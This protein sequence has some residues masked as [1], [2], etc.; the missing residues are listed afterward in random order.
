MI[1]F[2]LF[3]QCGRVVVAVVFKYE[4]GIQVGYHRIAYSLA[5]RLVV[6]EAE[7]PQ[8]AAS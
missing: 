5:C 7:G 8:F 1:R 3:C 4:H 6:R 2:E